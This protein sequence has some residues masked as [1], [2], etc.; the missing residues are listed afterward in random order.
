MNWNVDYKH[1][2]EKE[3]DQIL[4]YCSEL[5]L[6]GCSSPELS[7]LIELLISKSNMTW[8]QSP[9]LSLSLCILS[10][11]SL[12]V[13]VHQKHIN[14]FQLWETS[15]SQGRFRTEKVDQWCLI[16]LTAITLPTLTN[17]STHATFPSDRKLTSSESER[18]PLWVYPSF[19]R[20]SS[21]TNRAISSRK[22][23][24]NQTV[25]QTTSQSKTLAGNDSVLHWWV[26]V[27][28]SR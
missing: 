27:N 9:F 16:L 25:W 12:S 15:Q 8:L 14:L 24:V 17:S 23:T 2:T 28:D 3:K 5:S 18:D 1:V 13:L 7:D 10:V 20:S 19:Y 11:L 26:A 21:R 6:T 22:Q 4:W